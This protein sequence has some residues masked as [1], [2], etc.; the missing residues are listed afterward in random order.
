[1]YSCGT[2]FKK[3]EK[4]KKFNKQDSRRT[5]EY[6]LVDLRS[7]KDF[8]WQSKSW[9]SFGLCSLRFVPETSWVAL[10]YV[11]P[12]YEVVILRSNCNSLR[13]CQVNQNVSHVRVAYSLHVCAT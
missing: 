3:P 9:V 10:N 4:F 2:L 6:R 5:L 12:H 13:Y 1:V 11:L 7:G 8:D